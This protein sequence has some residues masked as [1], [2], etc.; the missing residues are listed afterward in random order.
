MPFHE[1]VIR[2]CRYISTMNVPDA[3]D[4]SKNRSHVT[5]PKRIALLAACFFWLAATLTATADE[6][7][8][9]TGRPVVV[10]FSG[11]VFFNVDPRDAIGLSKVWI[12]TADRTMKNSVPSNVVFLK[13]LEDIE[14]A[15]KNNRV[16]IVVLIAQEFAQLRER[17]PLSAV[18]SADYG[19]HFYDELLLLVRN[20][21]GIIRMEHMRGKTIRIES[22]QKGTIPILWL[23]S[24]L[25]ARYATDSRSFF[26]NITE[27][28]RASQVIMPVFFKQSD[29]CLASR[30]SLETM[31]EL[32]PQIGRSLRIL[33]TSPG[34]VT[35]LLAVR[36][37]ISN[38]RRDAMVK[39][40]LDIHN[41]PKGRQLLTV[42]RIN[43]LVEFHPEHLVTIDNVLRSGRN[44][45]EKTSRRK[46]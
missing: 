35:G 10:G 1:G 19:R 33:E 14:R 22:G 37:D 30:D 6:S 23:D 9:D 46:R 42:F 7:G 32:N 26:A 20:D 25:L 44:R 12:Q 18:L 13:D 41:D 3:S 39:T 15:L 31:S 16:D 29:A 11:K 43:R 4:V 17:V 24:Y 27:Y 21:S 5:V 2:I 36:R 45:V 8:P 38:P 34:F 28:P 40:I